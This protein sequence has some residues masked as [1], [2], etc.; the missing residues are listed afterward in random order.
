[1]AAQLGRRGRALIR[2]VTAEEI[3][4]LRH[5]V[6]RPAQPFEETA[7]PGDDLADTLHLG[8]FAE[9]GRLVGI[10][11]LYPEDRGGG[12]GGGWRLRGMAT[13]PDVRGAGFGA[14]LLGASLEHVA[15]SGGTEL[16]CNARMSAV[17]F[18]R[19]AGFE[20]LGDE[21]DVPGIGPHVVMA[22]EVTVASNR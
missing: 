12:P 1:M 2:R 8:A 4:P 13:D 16:W 21:F 9:E 15:S 17:G 10:A 22:R 5:R 11:S 20:V 18:Y 3:R 19:G 6:L 7:Y 14:A